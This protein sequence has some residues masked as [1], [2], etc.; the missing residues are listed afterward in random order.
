METMIDALLA[1]SARDGRSFNLTL[2]D[3][4]QLFGRP[5]DD[6]WREYSE[7]RGFTEVH[8]VLLRLGHGYGTLNDYLNRAAAEGIVSDRIDATDSLGRSALSWAVEHGWA[9]AAETL[10]RFGANVHQR[11]RSIYGGLPM[12][13][14]A[15]A[16]PT[17]GNLGAAFLDI[18]KMLI[19]AG[20]NV[21]ATD[22]EGWTP[23][24]IAASWNSYAAI[25]TLLE[26]SSQ[27]LN[28][29]AVTS[30]GQSASQ[31]AA[32]SGGDEALIELLDS[33]EL[34]WPRAG[35]P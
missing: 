20:A 17:S 6:L 32:E 27:S 15:L 8:Q 2:S 29:D 26:Y 30:S 25:R 19:L 34:H 13:H 14:V 21:N 11:T 31:I 12:L 18:V 7:T 28:W 16:G 1:E 9:Y 4:G 23:L 3:V 35:A 22:H 5:L 10:I 24:H 33:R